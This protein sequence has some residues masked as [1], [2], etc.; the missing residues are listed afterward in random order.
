[1]GSTPDYNVGEG[2]S[3]V[4]CRIYELE[5][6]LYRRVWFLPV[7]LE[8][9]HEVLGEEKNKQLTCGKRVKKSEK[10]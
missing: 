5:Y 3:S 9:S 6:G 8:A 2:P 10:K 7:R 1:M 4:L